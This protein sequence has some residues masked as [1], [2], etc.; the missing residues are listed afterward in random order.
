MS[1]LKL[2][3]YL[4]INRGE[5]CTFKNEP[6][7]GEEAEVQEQVGVQGVLLVVLVQSVLDGLQ[8]EVGEAECGRGEHAGDAG[9]HAA[10]VAWVRAQ[11][12]GGVPTNY[13]RQVLPHCNDL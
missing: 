3:F 13:E 12:G 2:H 8:H 7:G 4:L 5:K 10:V 6:P 1:L 9:V 11:L